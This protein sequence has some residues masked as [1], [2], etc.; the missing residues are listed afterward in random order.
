MKNLFI[1]PLFALFSLNVMAEASCQSLDLEE[2]M[3]CKIAKV[4]I[5]V[6]EQMVD[7]IIKQISTNGKINEEQL[8]NL[9][10]SAQ[11]LDPNKISNSI[12][13][14]LQNVSSPEAFKSIL[15]VK[16]DASIVVLYNSLISTKQIKAVRAI[17]RYLTQQPYKNALLTRFFSC[18]GFE[19]PSLGAYVEKYKKISSQSEL[20][21]EFLND[22]S[23]EAPRLEKE[24]TK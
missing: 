9:L 17:S 5:E 3:N 2:V 8:A 23:W 15:T 22:L 7:V 10:Q 18:A 19:E 13:R 1:I 4:K 20:A 21:Q 6:E 11:E 16:L 14:Y 12:I 24:C